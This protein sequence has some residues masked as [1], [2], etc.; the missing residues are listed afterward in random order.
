MADGKTSRLKER[1]NNKY[2]KKNQF[3]KHRDLQMPSI[4]KHEKKVCQTRLKN[5][6]CENPL[7]KIKIR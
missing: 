3:I 7:K 6:Q 4:T 5:N 2:F 1:Q